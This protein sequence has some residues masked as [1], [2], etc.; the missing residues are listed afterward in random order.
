MPSTLSRAALPLAIAGTLTL[1]GQPAQAA[2]FSCTSDGSDFNW[3]TAANWSSCNGL[4]PNNGADTFDATI[5]AGTVTLNSAVA[6]E[7][8]LLNGGNLN[9][10]G[11]T[12]QI[13]G[14]ATVGDGSSYLM[15]N[16]QLLGGTWNNTG[17]GTFTISN[18]S[19]NFLD[20]V[21]FNGNIDMSALSRV[22]VQNDLELN[23][24]IDL[25]N[26]SD[27]LSNGSNSFSGDGDI[28][29]GGGAGNNFYLDGNGT[30]TLGNNIVVRGENATIGGQNLVGGTQT[31]VVDGRISADVNGG[32]F[33]I[34]ESAVTNNG[35]LEAQ[36]GG[37][38]ILSSNVTGTAGS[39]IIAGAGSVVLQNGVT[40][41]GDINAAGTGSFQA[42]NSSNN[43]L[44]GVAF[45]GTLDLATILGRVRVQNDLDLTGAIAIDNGSDLL[46]NGTNVFSGSGDIVF[47]AAAGNNFYL[48]GN[49]TTTLGADIV[50]RGENAS[51][52]GQNLIGGTQTLVV[53]GRISADV[54]GGVFTIFESAVTNNGIL[55]AQ[56]GGQLILS[57]NVTGTAGSQIIAG[58]NSVVLQNGVTV[59]GD[60]NSVGTGSFRA[61]NSSNNFFD[62][63]SFS[64]NLDMATSEGRVRIINDLSLNG[65]IAL[66][67]GSDL[68]SNSSNVFSGSGDIVF[69]GTAG[70][71]FY[72]DGNGTTTL[73][74]DIVVRGENATIGGQNLIGGT[75]TL[76]V[77]GR[78]SANVN[79]GVFTILDSAVTNNGILE[80]QNGGQL[81]L[82]SNVTGNAG[83]QIIAGANSVVLQNGVTLSGVINAD[84]TG[85][86]RSSNSVNNFFDGVDFTGDL[87]LASVESRERIINGLTLNG[88]IAIDNGSDLYS[89]GSNVFDG[90]GSLV[91]GSSATGANN[92]YLDGNGTT[93]LGEDFVIRGENGTIGAQNQVGGTQILVVDGRISADTAG[94]VIN[95]VESAVS[96]NNLLEASNGGQLTLGSAVTNGPSGR[97]EA[98]DNS[99]VLQNGAAINGGTI[100]T[101]G[102][103]VLRASNSHANVLNG[104]AIEGQVD[105]ASATGIVHVINDLLLNGVINLDSGSDVYSDG[106]NAFTGAGSLAFG[107]SGGQNLF[108]DGNGTTSIGSDFTIRGQNGTIGNQALVGGTQTLS[109]DGL[110]T[111]DVD[112]GVISLVDSGV[113]VNAGGTLRAENGGTLLANVAV[114]N[115]GLVEALNASAVTYSP[116]GTT[117]NNIAG[118]LTG[119]IWR[120]EE[121]GDG[122]TIT[123]RGTNIHTNSADVTLKGAN[124]LIQVAATSI[125]DTLHTNE[126]SLRLQDGQA[127]TATANAGDFTNNGLLEITDSTFD[128]NSL[129][130]DG[131]INSF[132]TSSIT[133]ASG[134]QV[135][136]SGVI[137]ASF[138]TLTIDNG[139]D[140]QDGTINTLGTSP[141]PGGVRLASAVAD[142]RIGNLNNNG[143]LDLVSR[144]IVVTKDYTNA[145][146]GVGNDFD[147]RANVAGTG[148]LIGDGASQAITGDVIPAGP[149]VVNLDL[150]KLRGGTSTTINY[151]IANDGAP[152]AADIRGAIQTAVNGGNITDA[153]LSGSGVTAANFGPI[154]AG[155]D[156]GNLEITFDATTGGSLVGQAIAIKSNFDNVETDIIN[157][158]GLA[159]TLAQGSAT[160]DSDPVDIGPFRVGGTQPSQDFAV[161]NT[162]VADASTE[163]LGIASANTTGNFSATNNLGGGFIA[164]GDSQAAALTASVSGGQAGV[165]NGSLT[166]QYTTNGELIE[167]TFT[168]ID[169]NQQTINLQAT[170]FNAASGIA[171]P[172]PSSLGNVRV[173][174]VLEQQFTVAN[175]A[176]AGAFSEDLNSAFGA[177]TGDA[178]N[179]GGNITGL[180]AG[181]SDSSTMSASLDTTTSG[182]KNGTVTFNYQTSGEVDGASNGLGAADAGSQT[183]AL[184]G[185]VFQLAQ[186]TLN[187]PTSLNFG[188]VQV[189][190]AVSQLLSIINSASG[191]AGF[192]ED[193]NVAFGPSSGTG[194]NLISGSGS[195]MGLTA[196]ST[197]NSSMVV[198][199]DTSAAGSINGQIGI[200]YQSAGAVNGVSNGLGVLA[201]GSDSFGVIGTIDSSGNV[202]D[203]AQ[204]VINNG[205]INLGNVRQGSASPVGFASVTNMATG[206]DQAA[207]DATIS[208]NG[209]VTASGAF[210]NLAPGATDATSL[211]VG[212]DTGTAGAINDTATLHFVSD[213]SNI[214]NCAPNCEMVIASQDIDVTGAVYRLADPE[215]NTTDVTLAARVG[216]ALPTATVSVSNSSPDAFTEGLD[217][218]FGIASAGFSA[219]GSIDNLAA[220][221][222]D[223]SSMSVG[224]ASTAVSQNIAGSVDVDFESTGE[225]TTGEANI[226]VGSQSVNLSGKVYA[227]AEA[228]ISNTVI[229]FGTVRVGD[230]ASFTEKITNIGAGALVDDL[231]GNFAPTP[232]PFTADAG[233]LATGGVASGSDADLQF[234]MDTSAAGVFSD[235]IALNL[236]SHND[237]LADAELLAALFNVSG[238]VNQLANPA[239][240]F[241]SGDG[242][243]TGGGNL[244][245]LI[246]P[247]VQVGVDT[248]FNADLSVLNDVF[249]PSDMLDALFDLSGIGDFL[250]SGFGVIDDLAG[251]DAYGGL[252]VGFDSSLYSAGVYTGSIFL[253]GTSTFAGLD[254][255]ALDPI[256]LRITA[257]IQDQTVP[258]PGTV[259]LFTLG[260]AVLLAFRRRR[261][262][263][264]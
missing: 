172:D 62:A 128:S 197:D 166:V 51:I 225:G 85:S 98:A 34:L 126:G 210:D 108:M 142:S 73:G 24:Q 90:A 43:F 20:G 71:N 2:D 31:L 206:N 9:H 97:I 47:G 1:A 231:R 264:A 175:T 69:G 75:Q 14:Q 3:I 67:N 196:G 38:L 107:S 112:T 70:N 205:P 168:T 57:S 233:S 27:L 200:N 161:E 66:D 139:V 215:L 93:T 158:S 151:Q 212:L 152:G 234:A 252:M 209:A 246:F 229:D 227:Y 194:G 183:V 11:N 127:F 145:N 202:V 124:A 199:V 173:G 245:E 56:N 263:R 143:S 120:A 187:G 140:M 217:A 63:V 13:N 114:D 163:R 156:S 256:E 46:S 221:G 170:G 100:E 224:L 249:G 144:D 80:A 101:S 50:V 131:T 254:D 17:T 42:S 255:I 201:V 240:I 204:P 198:N 25:D 37:Q 95:I 189:G 33:N 181:A 106:S 116:S 214:G 35:I 32:V 208:G 179:N 133:A 259:A 77:D 64:G 243:L 110:V 141:T 235:S 83:S 115:Q 111:A 113:V 178:S 58:A 15:S 180:L 118:N 61:S 84:G 6:I 222:T 262:H 36:N 188:T 52:G 48:D 153:R 167:G 137:N 39:Q 218:S 60:I 89:S 87:D 182:A 228:S 81:T 236:Q 237:D 121:S 253:N 94:G 92:F 96:N 4:F 22:R 12:L 192:V 164:G 59:N 190:Q 55:E 203:Q 99:V 136:G 117:S 54:N 149:N 68:L 28:V 250:A 135:T 207:L 147:H 72:L 130:S 244:Y 174:G 216:D 40:I 23:G 160:P 155:T 8:L 18:S 177:N 138:G 119:G 220:Q 159:T 102:T 78:I 230:T 219:T 186:G 184:S 7:D 104:V 76:V 171:T 251:G 257:R 30:T 16:A 211:Q 169:A 258:V 123:L 132:G 239:F 157:V 242:V 26:G 226:G 213:A 260:G 148:Q 247:T 49:G 241:G 232:A 29:F 21:I 122:A 176:D 5:S 79:G 44:D 191:A 195:I 41:S 53:D 261:Q 125:E 88:A 238:T 10:T 134:N 129:A 150:G 105:L 103:G 146:F 74:E 185:N 19:N 109:V 248:L 82:S 223:A 165:N 154:A 65:E 45:T 162:S 91:F 193:L 86:F